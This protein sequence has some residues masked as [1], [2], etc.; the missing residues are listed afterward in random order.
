MSLLKSK[1]LNLLLRTLL[2]NSILSEYLSNNSNSI[3]LIH[4][5]VKSGKSEVLLTEVLSIKT[6][7]TAIKVSKCGKEYPW[8]INLNISSILTFDSV[9]NF[10]EFRD[11]IVW[12][13]N[14]ATRHQHF[15]HIPNVTIDD[16]EN[17]QEGF[18]IDCVHFIMNETRNSIKLVTGFMFTAG[19]CRINHFVTINRF[20]RSSIRWK[21]SVFRPEK[22]QNF[23]GCNLVLGKVDL[24]T[25][26]KAYYDLAKPLNF[27][28]NYRQFKSLEQAVS[29]KDVDLIEYTVTP[30]DKAREDVIIGFPFYFDYF[31]F[32]IPPGDL[33]TPLEK[34]FSPFEY[35]VWIWIAITLSIG[36]LVIQLINRC[37]IKIRNFVFG[38]DNVTPTLNMASTFLNGNQNNVPGRNFA[39]FFMMLFIIW[40][41]IIRTCYQSKLFKHLQSDIRKSAVK[42]FAELIERN[43]TFHE[44]EENFLGIYQIAMEEGL[45]K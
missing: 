41:L 14:K 26:I 1:T 36:A 38:R 20:M 37:P 4:F 8:K 2:S 42:T 22:Y 31:T 5:G 23:H 45:G 11:K 35:E 10:E 27:K 24:L 44:D 15:V 29:S 30:Q 40:F 19:R 43:F 16:L 33:L 17:I 12:Q 13:T 34:M 25:F 6:D 18:S 32:F 9:K 21:S 3:D 39:R 28:Y 7:S